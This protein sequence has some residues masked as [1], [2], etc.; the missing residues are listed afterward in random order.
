MSVSACA[1]L[2]VSLAGKLGWLLRTSVPW[3]FADRF[4]TVGA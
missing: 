4:E 3:V 1:S 2:S